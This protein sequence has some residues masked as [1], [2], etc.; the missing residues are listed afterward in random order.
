MSTIDIDLMMNNMRETAKTQIQFLGLTNCVNFIIPSETWR[1][2][3]N[4]KV[5]ERDTE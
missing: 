3:F 2:T 5:I 4:N 1:N